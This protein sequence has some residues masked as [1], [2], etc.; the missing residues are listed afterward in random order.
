MIGH[1]L[2]ATPWKMS[3][4]SF[5]EDQKPDSGEWQKSNLG[6]ISP[7]HVPLTTLWN[8]Q[9]WKHLNLA[10]WKEGKGKKCLRKSHPMQMLQFKVIYS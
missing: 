6:Q 7:T 3:S 10:Y 1:P 8:N 9:S 2:F 4:H 5:G